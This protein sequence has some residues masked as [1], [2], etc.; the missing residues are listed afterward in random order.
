MKRR[1][2][3]TLLGGAAAWPLAARA[4]QTMPVVGFL[5]PGLRE[6]LAHEVAAFHRGLNETGFTEGQN[7]A[8]EYRWAEGQYARLPA[9]AADLVGRQVAVIVAAGGAISA[10]VVK[11]ATTT[12]PTVMLSGGDPVKLGLVASMNRP[13][14]NITGVSQN[15][16]SLEA[17]RVELLCEVLPAATTIAVLV[18]PTNPNAEPIAK[19]LKTVAR[20]LGR[21]LQVLEAS[22]NADFD[23][24][25]ATIARHRTG[26]LV[27]SGDAFFVS[28]RDQL[29]ALSARH[30]LPAIYFVREFTDA[31]G[32]MSYG[33]DLA[34]AY[35]DVGIYTGKIL[36]GAK[37]ADLPVSQQST[38]VELVI[39]LK[40]ARALGLKIP[41]PLLGRADEV[42][43]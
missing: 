34:E 35:H 41:L 30:A 1:Q 16:L 15:I 39:N 23:A 26:G 2:F 4:Q 40:T 12:I 36:K 19:D 9:L 37:P 29:V 33:T 20:A 42:I 25:F 32:L 14:G 5:H 10:L 43:E 22:K 27:V 18:N 8:I 21:Q 38:K 31:G 13:G 17:K 11:A 6:P 3:I 24:A 28:Q 7:V